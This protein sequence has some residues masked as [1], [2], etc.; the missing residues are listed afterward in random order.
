MTLRVNLSRSTVE[1]YAQQLKDNGIDAVAGKFSPSA[2]YLETA[3]SVDQLPGFDEGLVS[4]QDEASQLVAPLMVT[5]N[6]QTLQVLD[7]C[8][9]PGGKTCHLLEL[10]SQLTLTA[11]DI[12][13]SRLKKVDENVDRLGFSCET[14]A[15]SL[16]SFKSE[17]NFDRI[18]LDAPCSATGIIRRHPD[19]KLLRRESDIDKLA[20][21]QLELLAVAWALLKDGGKLVYTTCSVLPEENEAIV[22]AFVEAT[23]SAEVVPIE[24]NWGQSTQHGRQ[25]LP[26]ENG[27]DGFFYARLKKRDL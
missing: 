5:Q 21:T 10:N 22:A 3:V 4:V 7:A 19:I 20:T 17:Q 16:E 27:T 12:D 13:E 26:T 1:S 23:D 11:L 9:A 15:V 2:L 18:L 8:A 25:I 6:D 14:I 24:E